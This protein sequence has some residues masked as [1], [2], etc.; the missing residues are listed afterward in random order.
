MSHKS[1][2]LSKQDTK[3][4]NGGGFESIKVWLKSKK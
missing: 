1:G 4:K 2:S 3:P